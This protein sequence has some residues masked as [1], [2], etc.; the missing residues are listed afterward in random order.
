MRLSVFT[1][2]AFV[3]G[4]PWACTDTAESAQPC[5]DCADTRNFGVVVP[6]AGVASG[7]E[8]VDTIAPP[9]TID[10]A[11]AALNTQRIASGLEP[12]T[13]DDELT[14]GCE[15]HIDYMAGEGKV[16]HEQTSTS[17][18]YTERGADAGPRSLIAGDVYDLKEAIALWTEG[19]YHRVALLDSG[20]SVIGLAFRDGYACLDPFGKWDEASADTGPL[21]P[22]KGQTDIPTTLNAAASPISPVPGDWDAP[23][24]TV[25]SIGFPAASTMGDSPVL[26]VLSMTSGAL[27][28]GTIRHPSDLD[29]PYAAL[30]GSTVALVPRKPLAPG[31]TYQAEFRGEIDG[32]EVNRIWQFSTAPEVSPAP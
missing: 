22:G 15:L 17:A 6:D 9:A 11:L 30:L 10:D 20:T 13:L 4:L 3:L 14:A 24:G 27:V 16:V 21:Y 1:S 28:D 23:T 31:T 18:F 29:D 32:Q 26:E 25:V 8:D 7:T 19:L 2:I 12:V 5:A